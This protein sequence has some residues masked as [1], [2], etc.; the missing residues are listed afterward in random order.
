MRAPQVAVQ[1]AGDRRDLGVDPGQGDSPPMTGGPQRAGYR[2]RYIREL[3]LGTRRGTMEITGRSGRSHAAAPQVVGF[4][5]TIGMTQRAGPARCARS[6]RRREQVPAVASDV[7]EHRDAAVGLGAWRGE[8]FNAGAGQALV[9]GV[10]VFDLQEEA[11][12]A[13]DLVPDGTCLPLAVSAGKQDAG[14]RPGRPDHHPPLQS[15]VIGRGWGVLDQ[16]EAQR[17]DEEGD[18]PVV[19]LDEDRDEL[20]ERHTVSMRATLCTATVDAR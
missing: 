15:A 19:V 13:S 4:P 5:D 2:Y 20:H 1:L 10:E 7:E 12:S 16:L 14:L 11:D 3:P 9:G 18:G 17:A 6:G 8:E